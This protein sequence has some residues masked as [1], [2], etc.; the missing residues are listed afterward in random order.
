MM[1]VSPSGH[2]LR[3]AT[4]VIEP[5]TSHVEHRTS[6]TKVDPPGIEPGSPVCRTGVV[7]LD[8]EPIVAPSARTVVDGAGFEPATAEPAVLQ[9]APLSLSGTRPCQWRRWESNP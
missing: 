6:H 5:L 3:R 7:P 9:T 2:K 8:H 4:C 1:S